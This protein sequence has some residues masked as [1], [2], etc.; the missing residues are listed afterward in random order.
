[1]KRKNLY[2]MVSEMQKTLKKLVASDKRVHKKMKHM[3]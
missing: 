2:C 3:R 1:M